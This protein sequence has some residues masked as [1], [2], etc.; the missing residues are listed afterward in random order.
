MYRSYA[1]DMGPVSLVADRRQ[2]VGFAP[3]ASIAVPGEKL[4]TDSWIGQPACCGLSREPFFSE[5]VA[6]LNSVDDYLKG[7]YALTT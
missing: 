1:S 6:L 4:G 3:T 7:C 5:L 2:E